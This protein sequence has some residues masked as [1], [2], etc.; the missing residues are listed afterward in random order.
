MSGDPSIQ[1]FLFRIPR[2]RLRGRAVDDCQSISVPTFCL[3]LSAPRR[4]NQLS[5][6]SFFFSFH[7]SSQWRRV[8]PSP[9]KDICHGIFLSQFPVEAFLSGEAPEVC[10][11]RP[12][13]ARHGSTS[14][15]KVHGTIPALTIFPF[16]GAAAFPLPRFYVAAFPL[17][18]IRAGGGVSHPRRGQSIAGSILFFFSPHGVVEHA[19]PFPRRKSLFYMRSAGLSPLTSLRRSSIAMLC[20]LMPVFLFFSKM[21]SM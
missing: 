4:R 11:P 5:P 19:R 9:P 20:S 6:F 18:H 3:L 7:N 16:F 8:G 1:R 15:K 2:G 17:S 21:L 14:E 12:H 10:H 13:Q